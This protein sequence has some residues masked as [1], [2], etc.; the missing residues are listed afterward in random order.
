MGNSEDEGTP[1]KTEQYDN[2]LTLTD[3][4]IHVRRYLYYKF[5]K[6]KTWTKRLTWAGLTF[7]LIIGVIITGSLFSKLMGVPTLQNYQARFTPMEH[8]DYCE[9]TNQG[10]VYVTDDAGYSCKWKELNYE[11]NCCKDSHI[12]LIPR[13]SCATCNPNSLCC[14]VYEFCVSC[15][16]DPSHEEIRDLVLEQPEN[17]K[18]RET[19]DAFD[20][21]RAVC[22]TNSKAI[23]AT[24]QYKNSEKYCFGVEGPP[25]YNE[26][27]LESDT[28]EQHSAGVTSSAPGS[29][30]AGKVEGYI[31]DSSSEDVVSAF[32]YGSTV[33][34]SATVTTPA[35]FIV[36]CIVFCLL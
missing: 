18:L 15:C 10:K 16:M 30:A 31:D 3:V 32:K 33:R 29:T 22:R 5:G 6:S 28:I 13:Y 8:D 35:L 1:T 36:L 4:M 14:G 12:T 27:V 2:D 24:N 25:L 21:C 34:S 17:I 11:T 19:T 26:T 23:H 20:Y 7:S 9:H